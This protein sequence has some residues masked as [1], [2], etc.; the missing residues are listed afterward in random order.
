[1]PPGDMAAFFPE[2][3]PNATTMSLCP[4]ITGQEVACCVMSSSSPM[5]CGSSAFDAPWL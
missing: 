2:M 5:T 1:M 3:P 4:A